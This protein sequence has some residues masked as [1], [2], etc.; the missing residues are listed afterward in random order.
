MAHYDETLR[1]YYDA[2]ALDYDSMYTRSD[3]LWQKELKVLTNAIKGA[4]SGRRVLEVACG[5]GIWS[6]VAAQVAEYVV[7][8][9]ASK[10]ML[11]MARKKK[12]LS[13]NVEY[14]RGDAYAL[15]TVLGKFDA[16][17]ANF[18]FSHIPKSRIDEFLHRWHGKLGKRAVVFMA[19]NVYVPGIGGQLVSKP[20]IEDTFK[21]RQSSDS[22]KY[23]VLKNYYDYD[24][25]RRVLFPKTVNLE[26]Y[27]SQYFWWVKYLVP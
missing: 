19:D 4:V 26:V 3:R 16:G 21:L 2:S 9:D 27:E 13:D 18:W 22:S 24:S 7:A 20:G 23:E 8:V 14:V 17:L 25:L 5:T 15:A 12:P 11:A 1:K 10:E 6:Q